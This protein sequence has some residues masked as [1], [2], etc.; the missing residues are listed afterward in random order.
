MV[1]RVLQSGSS[2]AVESSIVDAGESVQFRDP[3]R[4]DVV[5][6][7]GAAGILAPWRR[8]RARVMSDQSRGIRRPAPD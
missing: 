5:R 3:L 6:R 7:S 1:A 4:A 2:G 8:P